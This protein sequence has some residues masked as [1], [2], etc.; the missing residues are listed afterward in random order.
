MPR[1]TGSCLTIR[2]SI[3]RLSGVGSV[4]LGC[5]GGYKVYKSGELP[6]K[7]ELKNR[8]TGEA[9]I[10]M[11]PGASNLR[12][13]YKFHIAAYLCADENV[14]SKRSGF[15]CNHNALTN[16]LIWADEIQCN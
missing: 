9:D 15:L 14:V 6:F 7:V 11:L 8:H 3:V 2:V 12:G 16:P 1:A 10:V 4:I 13:V 5:I